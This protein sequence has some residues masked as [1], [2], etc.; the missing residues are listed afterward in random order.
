MQPYP[1]A[2]LYPMQEG[3][4]LCSLTLV[5][6]SIPCNTTSHGCGGPGL[7]QA[8]TVPDPTQP[9]TPTHYPRYTTR[10][11]HPRPQT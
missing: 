11:P 6:C 2:M 7:T 3:L 4:W 8:L 10:D 1:R 9:T 5:P